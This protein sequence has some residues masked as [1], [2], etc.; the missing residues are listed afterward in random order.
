MSATMSTVP[1]GPLLNV[2]G[3]GPSDLDIGRY[4]AM[5]CDLRSM[6]LRH[7][8]EIYNYLVECW[9]RFVI[10]DL[11]IHSDVIASTM[12]VMP[13]DMTHTL[14]SLVNTETK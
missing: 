13:N 2:Y 11:I 7:R 4:V 6:K 5:G 9:L 14:E 12:L 3:R 10:D 1:L 8:A